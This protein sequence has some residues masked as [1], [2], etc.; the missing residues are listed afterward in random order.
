[1]SNIYDEIPEFCEKTAP[2]DA[3][4][5][6]IQ[7]YACKDASNCL[8]DT[9]KLNKE[10]SEYN[11]KQSDNLAIALNKYNTELKAYNDKLDRWEKR[12]GEFEKFKKYDGTD[13]GFW[14][15]GHDGTCWWGENWNG[16]HDWC[17]NAANNKG[18]D[19]EN[20]WAKEWGWCSG[21]YGNFFCKKPDDIILK[22]KREYN[23]AKPSF[24]TSKP[25]ELDF[26][27]K[28]LL[29][30]DI[31]IQCC[32]NYLGGDAEFTD[33][34][35]LCSQ[36]I[37]TKIQSLIKDPESETQEQSQQESYEQK[38][39]IP[40]NYLIITVIIIVIIIIIIITVGVAF[41]F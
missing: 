28:Q 6:L 23:D 26:P 13:R 9:I 16:A 20:Y 10:K 24:S 5:E 27:K 36:I 33:N 11:K 40:L 21:R 30:T 39:N 7:L 22:Q 31:N 3:D 17:H 19:G 38:S 29:P 12:T 8:S 32:S 25:T 18:Y 15:N 14:A 4:K 41:I 37:E 35:Q 2:K 1:M 34:I